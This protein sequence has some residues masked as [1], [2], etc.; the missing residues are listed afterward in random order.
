[1]VL[2]ISIIYEKKKQNILNNSAFFINEHT[3]PRDS[4]IK[5]E[6]DLRKALFCH[7]VGY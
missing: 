4:V 7:S 2:N 5:K 1:M 3:L 6:F